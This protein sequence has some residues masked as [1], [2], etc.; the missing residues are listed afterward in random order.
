MNAYFSVLLLFQAS[1]VVEPSPEENIVE[2][3]EEK[4]DPVTG[5]FAVDSYTQSNANAG[6]RPFKTERI[7]AEFGRTGGNPRVYVPA[8]GLLKESKVVVEF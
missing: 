2:I 7:A 6:A 1:P 5:E 4:P 8:E 3:I